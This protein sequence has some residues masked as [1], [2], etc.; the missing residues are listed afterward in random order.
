MVSRIPLH[1]CTL[2]TRVLPIVHSHT[3]LSHTI[4]SGSLA[5]TVFVSRHVCAWVGGWT[6]VCGVETRDILLLCHVSLVLLLS[7]HSCTFLHIPP[8]LP[9]SSTF[10]TRDLNINLSHITLDPT[11]LSPTT[12][13]YTTLSHIHLSPITLSHFTLSLPP[14][15]HVTLSHDINITLSHSTLAQI[16]LSLMNL[17]RTTLSRTA[18]PPI[19]LSHSALARTALSQITLSCDFNVNLSHYTLSHITLS[20]PHSTPNSTLP[21]YSTL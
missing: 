11:T 16:T 21:L 4:A 17:S 19:T 8:I 6:W 3:T 5:P 1:C 12:L 2:L 7:R 9:N 14:L 13:S 10:L 20:L 15:L 18:L